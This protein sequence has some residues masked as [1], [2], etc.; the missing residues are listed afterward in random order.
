M[1]LETKKQRQAAS[2]KRY[3]EKNK[4]HLINVANEWNKLNK[5]KYN[6]THKKYYI[7]NHDTIRNTKILCDCGIMITKVSKAV[8]Y[9]TMKHLNKIKHNNINAGNNIEASN[10]L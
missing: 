9:K 10:I 1:E 3:Y 6:I 4:T 2:C 8:H 5:D 7:T